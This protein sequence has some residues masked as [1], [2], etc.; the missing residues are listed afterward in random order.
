MPSSTPATYVSRV[1]RSLCRTRQQILGDRKQEADALELL[2]EQCRR[3]GNA[4]DAVKLLQEALKV[5]PQRAAS[6]G[7]L[8]NLGNAYG[9]LGGALKKRDLIKRA[10]KIEE[11]Y[12]G[13]DHQE[14]AEKILKRGSKI[15]EAAP[16]EGYKEVAI[17]LNSLGCAY[18]DLGDALQ[19]RLLLELALMIKEVYF[20]EDH[21]EVAFT[22]DSLGCAY[23]ARGDAA[24]HRDILERALKIKEAYFGEDHKEVACTLNNLGC[25]YGDLGD[26]AKHRDLL[27]RAL[28][29]NEGLTLARTTRKWRSSWRTSA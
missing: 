29:I 26:A 11:A 14:L 6:A 18:G 8:K 13:W 5:D 25:A 19:Q 15:A 3:I 22:L 10:L 9:D 24:K 12:F 21:K 17:T 16:R 2:A 23:G 1:C 4:T 20:G 7:S 28:K 27:E